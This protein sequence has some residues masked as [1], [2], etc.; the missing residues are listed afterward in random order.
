[1]NHEQIPTSVELTSSDSEEKEPQS[2]SRLRKI[3]GKVCESVN[4][5]SLWASRNYMTATAI[6]SPFAL[7]ALDLHPS[8]VYKLGGII[9]VGI[10]TGVAHSSWKE[11]RSKKAA[12][13]TQESAAQE[14]DGNDTPVV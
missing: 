1:M 4:L 3:G 10:A 11:R 8:P 9:G 13:K 6:A 12:E 7:E 5:S 14:L 2:P